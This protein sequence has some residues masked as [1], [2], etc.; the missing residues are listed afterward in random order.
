MHMGM[1]DVV[2]KRSNKT[3]GRTDISNFVSHYINKMKFKFEVKKIKDI[4]TDAVVSVVFEDNVDSKLEW[5]NT[6]YKG[7]LASLIESKDF[8]GAHCLNFVNYIHFIFG[9]VFFI[10][11]P[12]IT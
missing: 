6:L 8:T 7:G 1:L 4:K 12:I 10:F 2:F 5:L 3:F 11:S 9:I